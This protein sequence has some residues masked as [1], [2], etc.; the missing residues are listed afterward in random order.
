[1]REDGAKATL[2]ICREL[3]LYARSDRA[4]LPWLALG[5]MV[6][7]RAGL[8]DARAACGAARETLW[9]HR[10]AAGARVRALCGPQRTTG[11]LSYLAF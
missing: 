4:A 8:P 7:R 11:T 3:A 10:L 6:L 9:W 5:R 2:E 1:M